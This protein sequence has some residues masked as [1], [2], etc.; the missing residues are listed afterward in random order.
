MMGGKSKVYCLS[1]SKYFFSLVVNQ[2]LSCICWHVQCIWQCAKSLLFGS[3]K[4]PQKQGNPAGLPSQAVPDSVCPGSVEVTANLQQALLCT[5]A[6]ASAGSW[7][8]WL[9]LLILFLT[10]QGQAQESTALHVGHAKRQ[11]SSWAPYR[12]LL[13][14]APELADTHLA[15]PPSFMPPCYEVTVER[16][17]NKWAI[18]AKPLS[19]QN[20]SLC[21]RRASGAFVRAYC[22]NWWNE[23][24]L[25]IVHERFIFPSPLQ[26]QTIINEEQNLDP[27]SS[28]TSFPAPFSLVASLCHWYSEIRSSCL[29]WLVIVP[30]LERNLI[31]QKFKNWRVYPG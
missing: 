22:M 10:A 19:S 8:A 25:F 30:P 14:L 17:K 11:H 26:V 13:A 9:S 20:G 28:P 1:D 27:W 31:L 5:R 23:L 7:A 29:I 4:C 24:L 6:V 2:T 21:T 3:D 15:I 18:R 12:C 16:Q